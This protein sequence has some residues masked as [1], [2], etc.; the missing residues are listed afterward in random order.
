M[1][2]RVSLSGNSDSRVSAGVCEHNTTPRAILGCHTQNFVTCVGSITATV[3]DVKVSLDSFVVVSLKQSLI[4]FGCP[5]SRAQS[6][7]LVLLPHALASTL[8]FVL[9]TSHRDHHCEDDPRQGAEFGRLAEQSPF[10]GHEPNSLVELCRHSSRGERAELRLTI[11]A[12]TPL[13]HPL[14]RRLM[15]HKLWEC[16][17]HH[18]T[19]RRER[20]SGRC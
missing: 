12:R 1:F 18:Y 20:E 13:Q 7:L 10:T 4:I 15:M 5:M 19:S 2:L 6:E 14:T 17:L 11:Q 8:S 9:L 16:W 3:Q